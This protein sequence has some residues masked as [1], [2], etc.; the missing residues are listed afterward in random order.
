MQIAAVTA[1]GSEYS[2]IRR[3]V[4]PKSGRRLIDITLFSIY[5]IY[6]A[7]YVKPQC[8]PI[9]IFRVN[10]IALLTLREAAPRKS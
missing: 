9:R 7:L 1:N 5:Y 3:T 2:V 10:W 4:L 8:A 6:N